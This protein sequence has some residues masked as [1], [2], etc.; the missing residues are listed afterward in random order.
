MFIHFHI[1]C[2]VVTRR[3]KDRKAIGFKA[4]IYITYMA[5]LESSFVVYKINKQY[6]IPNIQYYLTTAYKQGP[7]LISQA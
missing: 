3:L 2:T 1:R 7:G 6:E 5:A 4:A